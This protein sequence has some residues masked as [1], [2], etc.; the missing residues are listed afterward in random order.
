MP[1]H[2]EREDGERERQSPPEASAEIGEF[3]VLI[4]LQTRHHWLERHAADRAVAG[5]AAR[6]LRVH[7]AGVLRSRRRRFHVDARWLHVARGVR[8][9][10]R[11]AAGRAESVFSSAMDRVMRRVCLHVHP[12]NGVEE[13]RCS[14]VPC[15]MRRVGR[16]VLRLR[17]D[18]IG[19]H[20]RARI[21]TIV[22]AG[23]PIV[24]V[25]SL[26]GASSSVSAMRI[27]PA[28]SRFV[29]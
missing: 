16:M 6:D 18:T 1:E 26:H 12:A 2:G 15:A 5:C 9:E 14:R 27:G 20:A 22:T 19:W 25:A 24:I 3:R 29:G 17:R 21:A 23:V 11:A 8:D 7:G 4:V 13:R 28:S 10:L